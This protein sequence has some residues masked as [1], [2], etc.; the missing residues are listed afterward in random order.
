MVTDILGTVPDCAVVS[1]QTNESAGIVASLKLVTSEPVVTDVVVVPEVTT[2]A[3]ARPPAKT[4]QCFSPMLPL[5][6]RR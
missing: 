2:S 1:I 4:L 3:P 5:L 6:L